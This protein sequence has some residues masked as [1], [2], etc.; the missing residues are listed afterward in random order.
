MSTINPVNYIGFHT[1]DGVDGLDRRRR[2]HHRVYYACGPSF[3]SL[4]LLSSLTQ[5]Y[6]DTA[7]VCIMHVVLPFHHYYI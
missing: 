4:P 5:Q 6:A 1:L 2:L 7:I 3:S